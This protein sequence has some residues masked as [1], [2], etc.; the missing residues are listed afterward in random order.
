MEKRSLLAAIAIL[1]I[2]IT[3]SCSFI[4]MKNQEKSDHIMMAQLLPAR[5][6]KG[7]NALKN[8]NYEEAAQ[9]FYAFD[10][11]K[12]KDVQQN[13]T[14]SDFINNTY[15]NGKYLYEY[16]NAKNFYWKKDFKMAESYIKEIPDNYSGE[17]ADD[18]AKIKKRIGKNKSLTIQIIKK[19]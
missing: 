6:E 4:E 11:K 12:N 5:Y 13:K 2:F 1:I 14:I 16:S 9:Q 17:F 10:N 3:G 19:K 15:P 8:M 18:V 7:L